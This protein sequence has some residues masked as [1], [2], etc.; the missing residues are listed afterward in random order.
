M[1][2]CC[3]PSCGE[4]LEC[5]NGYPS[6]VPAAAA[7]H[8]EFIE[9]AVR[10]RQTDPEPLGELRRRDVHNVILPVAPPR[11]TRGAA[12]WASADYTP[13]YSSYSY[14]CGRSAKGSSS[15]VRL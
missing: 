11:K 8:S 2:W 13:K 9:C 3:P 10:R 14:G 7:R 12:Q 1:P 4:A 15:F 5:T 6:G